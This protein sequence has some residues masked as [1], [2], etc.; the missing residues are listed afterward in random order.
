[1]TSLDLGKR[2]QLINEALRTEREM[3]EVIAECPDREWAREL[4]NL[5]KDSAFA[6]FRL[7]QF[8]GGCSHELDESWCAAML[9]IDPT[10]TC[11]CGHVLAL[12]E[13][14]ARPEA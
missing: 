6:E 12:T 5:A 4:A 8:L 14:D 1:M 10:W 13:G 9:V 3:K 11:C 2:G 7:A